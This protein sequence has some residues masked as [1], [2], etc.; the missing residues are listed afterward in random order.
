MGLPS[1]PVCFLALA[2]L[3][4]AVPIYGQGGPPFRTDDP[5]TPGN[6]HWEINIGMVGERNLAEGAYALPNLD[7]NYGLGER[8]QLKYELPLAIQEFRGSHVAGGIGNSL[9]GVKWRFYQKKLKRVSEKTGDDAPRFAISTYPQV[10]LNNPTNA[11]ARGIVERGPQYLLPIEAEAKIGPVRI[12]LENGRWLRRDAPDLWIHG[13]MLGRQFTRKT[14]VYLE[15]YMLRQTHRSEDGVSESELTVG[16]GTRR[17]ITRGG[18]LRLLAMA[19]RS[20]RRI[21]AWNSEPS[22]IAY[23]GLQFRIG[24]ETREPGG[25]FRR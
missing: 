12:C 15:A 10:I 11:D 25:D 8:I 22:W 16:I 4:A 13:L 19:G 1:P 2:A 6:R 14:E 5:D 7:V 9:L 3:V 17:P 20:P 23:I 21:R 24:A 18:G